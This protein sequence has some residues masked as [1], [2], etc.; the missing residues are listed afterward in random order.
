MKKITLIPGDGIGPEVSFSA[1]RVVDA[2]NLDIDWEVINAGAEIYEKTGDFIPDKLINSINKN[3]VALKGPI[4]TPIGKGFRSINVRL[5][6]KFDTYANIRPLKTI[7]GVKS[8]YNNI[9]LVVFRENTE[10]LYIGIEDKVSEDRAEAK[11]VITRKCCERIGKKAFEYAKINNRKK[12]T[13]VH[14]ANILKITDGMFLDTIRRISKEYSEIEYEEKIVD[15]MC[16]QLVMYPEN[17]DVIVTSNLYGDILSD[18][19]SGLVGGLGLVPGAN[20]GKDVGIFEAVHGSAPD[21][22]GRFTANP[23][24][25][26]LS[27]AMMLDY[28]KYKPEGD[29]IRN[30]INKVIGEGKTLTKDLGGNSSTQEFTD[31]IIEN[32]YK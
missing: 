4:T 26:I 21:I 9:D 6:K 27:A 1:K 2:L 32:L 10:G 28:I 24:A 30:S 23:T 16:M 8:R 25:C 14:K 12:V 11:K 3:K 31:E 17:H 15:N 13:A 29:K 7:P 19:S 22:A 20:I 5:R 18:L